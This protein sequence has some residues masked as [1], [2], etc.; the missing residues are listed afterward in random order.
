MNKLAE[1]LSHIYDEK[2]EIK[3]VELDNQL[4]LFL[5]QAYEFFEGTIQGH[6]CLFCPF[7]SLYRTIAYQVPFLSFL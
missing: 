3:K 2:I 7:Q 5:Q 1:Y 4:P 6:F